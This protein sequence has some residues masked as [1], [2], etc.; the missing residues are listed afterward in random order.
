VKTF[1]RLLAVLSLMV[2][3]ASEAQAQPQCDE[4]CKAVREG[5]VIVGWSCIAGTQ[6]D[7]CV[8]YIDECSIAQCEISSIRDSNGDFLIQA[9][10][11]DAATAVVEALQ[12]ASGGGSRV[13]AQAA[14]PKSRINAAANLTAS[15]DR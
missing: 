12:K 10:R 13:A 1:F 3:G 9:K 15:L 4:A 6:G 2:V 8:A 7:G 5:T 11:C 14:K